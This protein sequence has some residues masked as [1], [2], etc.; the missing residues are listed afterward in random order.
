MVQ[1]VVFDMAGTTVDER[2]IVYKTVQKAIQAAGYS[3]DLETVLIYAA[4]REKLSAI[5]EVLAHLDGETDAALPIFHHFKTLLRTVY[6]EEEVA[7][8][9]NAEK[10]FQELQNRNIKVVLNTGYDRNTTDQLL[11]K[12]NWKN[13]ELIDLSICASDVQNGRPHPDMINLAMEKLNI[14][15]PKSVIKVGDSTVD[16]VEGINAGCLY[17]LGITTGAHTADQLQA[18]EPSAVIN[19]L[20]EVLDFLE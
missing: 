9:P 17:N 20:L 10:V 5:T 3:V 6:E 18:A 1:A 7:A 16:I 19:N 14:E 4:G 12:L 2:N 11:T 15:D 8:Q 13:S